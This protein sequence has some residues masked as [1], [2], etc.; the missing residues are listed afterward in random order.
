MTTIRRAAV[1]TMVVAVVAIIAAVAGLPS[2]GAA[3]PPYHT[4]SGK[5]FGTIA[6]G[7]PAGV[8]SVPGRHRP[9]DDA[10]SPRASAPG[11]GRTTTGSVPVHTHASR[12]D[13]RWQP[14]MASR[15]PGWITAIVEDMAPRYGLD[16]NLVLSVMAVES[17]FQVEAR[18]HKNAQG[19]MQLIPD[20]AARFGIEKPFDARQNIRGGMAYLQWLLDYFEGDIPLA[21]AGYNAGE[22][23]V[24]R[25]G[26]IPPYAETRA[27]VENV[28]A[29]YRCNSVSDNPWLLVVKNANP[30]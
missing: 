7:R 3:Q 28:Q 6:V 12:C 25:H 24:D 14:W 22:N 4:Q 1:H 9:S 18:S 30:R 27:Y 29:I 8:M 23:A 2:P 17:R 21:L 13:A 16:P 15:A 26:G 11:L 20:T 10:K 5:G 19:L